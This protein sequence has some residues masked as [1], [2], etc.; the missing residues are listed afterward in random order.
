MMRAWI[1]V[2]VF[3][4]WCLRDQG[5]G[6][7][8]LVNHWGDKAA[9]WSSDPSRGPARGVLHCASFWLLAIQPGYGCSQ[10]WKQSPITMDHH[11]ACFFCVCATALCSWE[12]V[13]L[14]NS[15]GPA[16]YENSWSQTHYPSNDTSRPH[17]SKT[18]GHVIRR[19]TLFVWV[20]S[21]VHVG[22]MT[23]H[24]HTQPGNISATQSTMPRDLPVQFGPVQPRGLSTCIV[25]AVPGCL[26]LHLGSVGLKASVSDSVWLAW[27][28]L[29]SNVPAFLT[30]MWFNTIPQSRRLLYW[31]LCHL[32]RE[33]PWKVPEWE[34]THHISILRM[35]I[36]LWVH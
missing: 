4:S 5:L 31:L 13:C 15:F 1:F 22:L 32:S 21:A 19:C 20:M 17:G 28:F 35:K 26:S 29:G 11:W 10:C 24:M 16:W 12:A 6:L 27:R 25:R 23:R 18:W 30:W 34:Q 14:N 3:W 33:W 36:N 9:S 2:A 8:R 7:E